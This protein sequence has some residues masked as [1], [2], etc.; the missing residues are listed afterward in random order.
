[1]LKVGSWL[2]FSCQFSEK[3]KAVPKVGATLGAV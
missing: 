1:M 2:V 3:T